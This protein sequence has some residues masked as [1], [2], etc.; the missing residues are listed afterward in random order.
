MRSPADQWLALDHALGFLFQ[1]ICLFCDERATNGRFCGQGHSLLRMPETICAWCGDLLP[2]PTDH[3]GQCLG[4]NRLCFPSRSCFLLTDDAKKLVHAIKYDSLPQLLA[5]IVPSLSLWNPWDDLAE[6]CL[7]PVPLHPRKFWKRGFN[8]SEKIAGTLSQAWNL[9]IDFSLI[10]TAE[11][12][13]QTGLNRTARRKNLKNV[14][15]WEGAPPKKVIV[16]DDVFTTGATLESCVNVLR[17]ANAEEIR[18]VT[19]FR[20]PRRHNFPIRSFSECTR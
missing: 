2:Q 9:R 18:A 14:F 15:A 16:V 12:Q 11:R 8:F 20:T 5:L 13:D 17:K 10:K 4:E 19:V 6:F 1:T 7:V 3:C